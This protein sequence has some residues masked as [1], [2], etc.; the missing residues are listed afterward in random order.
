MDGQVDLE[1]MSSDSDFLFLPGSV[2]YI[3]P[4][5]PDSEVSTIPVQVLL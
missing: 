5:D 2:M 4:P 3:T 1:K